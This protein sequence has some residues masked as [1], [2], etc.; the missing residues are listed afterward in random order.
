MDLCRDN[1]LLLVHVQSVQFQDNMQMLT[2][3]VYIAL[4]EPTLPILDVRSV[5]LVQWY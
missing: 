4:M 2:M 5:L 1:A 3:G